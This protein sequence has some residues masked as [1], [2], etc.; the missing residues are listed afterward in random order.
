MSWLEAKLKTFSFASE[1]EGENKRT[2]EFWWY[3]ANS[4]QP[5]Y[6]RLFPPLPRRDLVERLAL[7]A[8]DFGI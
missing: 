5:K 8:Q 4:N 2:E 6:L 1:P 3:V 7:H